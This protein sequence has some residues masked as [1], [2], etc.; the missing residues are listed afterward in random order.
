LLDKEVSKLIHHDEITSTSAPHVILD[1]LRQIEWINED[2]DSIGSEI[3]NSVSN[4]LQIVLF[5]PILY[6]RVTIVNQT[7]G[8]QFIK[9]YREGEL[10]LEGCQ[11]IKR[12]EEFVLVLEVEVLSMSSIVFIYEL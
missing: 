10:V 6:D 7:V 8:S 3:S 5:N 9:L 11:I 4:H 2:I 1:Y 12:K